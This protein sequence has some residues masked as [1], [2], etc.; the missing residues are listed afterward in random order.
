MSLD[1]VV[2]VAELLWQMFLYLESEKTA[3]EMS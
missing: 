1:A 3:H 2:V